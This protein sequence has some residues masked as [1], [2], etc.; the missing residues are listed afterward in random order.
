MEDVIIDGARR[1]DRNQVPANRFGVSFIQIGDDPD[2]AEFLREIDEDISRQHNCRVSQRTDPLQI[3]L[4]RCIHYQDMVNATPYDPQNPEFTSD[5]FLKCVLGSID[6][7]CDNIH[8]LFPPK[9]APR[10][11]SPFISMD[12][13]CHVPYP[14]S[15]RPGVRSTPTPLH[16]NSLLQPM[17]SS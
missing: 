2:A 14:V 7:Y 10:A 16:F 4:I 12:Y 3:G 17:P 6:S 8:P 13:G 5:G 15:P 1:L 9:L 11:S